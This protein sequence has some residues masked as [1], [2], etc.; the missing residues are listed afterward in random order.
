MPVM[1]GQ[2]KA[3]AMRQLIDAIMRWGTDCLWIYHLHDARDG[4]AKEITTTTVS[5]TE[6]ARLLRCI[7]VQLEIIQDGD[8]RGIKGYA[9]AAQR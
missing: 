6:I 5:Q 4:K 8:K 3:L 2:E 7:N 9:N 1:G